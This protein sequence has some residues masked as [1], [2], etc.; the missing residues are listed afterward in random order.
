MVTGNR[1]CP[2]LSPGCGGGEGGG[3]ARSSGP[4]GIILYFPLTRE[5]AERFDVLHALLVGRGQGR[6]VE[7][8]D[9]GLAVGGQALLDE[10]Q[11]ADEGGLLDQVGGDQ[12]GGLVLAAAQVGVLDQVG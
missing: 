8:G 6:D 2:A 1:G 11:R 7:G 12:G 5:G 4:F 9:A 3:T 10:A